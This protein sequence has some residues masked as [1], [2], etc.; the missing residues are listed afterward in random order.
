MRVLGDVCS[1]SLDLDVC[2][3]A[4]DPHACTLS[5]EDASDACALA[6]IHALAFEMSE[7]EGWGNFPRFEVLPNPE[8][9]FRGIPGDLSPG[10][11]FP[12]DMSPGIHRTEKL[13][14]D[15]FSGEIPGRHRW[16]YIVSVKQLSATVEGFPGRHVAWETIINYLIWRLPGRHVARE[17]SK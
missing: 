10:I 5:F 12:G 13:E 9:Q 15:T 11:G 16:A 4:F 17:C 2:S 3:L 1:L 14:W 8:R 7:K 6:K